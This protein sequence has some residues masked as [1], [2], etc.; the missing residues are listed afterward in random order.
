MEKI[1]ISKKLKEEKM[2]KILSLIFGL[3][4]IVISVKDKEIIKLLLGI[5]LIFLSIYKREVYLS[6]QGVVY[7]YE[8]LRFKRNE[9]I[10]FKDLDE[11]TIVKQRGNCI[12]FFVK[13]PMA[14]KLVLN[15]EKLDEMI[16]FIKSKSK[17]PLR[18]ESYT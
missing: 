6:E 8:A 13:E 1:I 18:F 7:T 9:Y 10:A 11:I 5:L 4:L 3:S 17:V 16:E 14:K 2:F 12:A 15:E